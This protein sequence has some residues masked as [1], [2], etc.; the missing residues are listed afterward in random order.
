MVSDWNEF[1]A[2][3]DDCVTMCM[4]RDGLRWE[5]APLLKH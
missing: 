2:L 3:L 5:R 1:E 4:T